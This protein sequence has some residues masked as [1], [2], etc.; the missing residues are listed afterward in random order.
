MGL[1]KIAIALLVGAS[2]TETGRKTLRTLG[3]QLI[4]MGQS[5]V[6][7]SSST[8]EELKTQTTKLIEEAKTE[9]KDGTDGATKK[10]HR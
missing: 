3:K 6:E 9:Y 8:I 5:A 7:K 1:W 10:E 4:D 2:F